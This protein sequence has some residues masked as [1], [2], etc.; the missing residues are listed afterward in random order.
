[1][2]QVYCLLCV[3]SQYQEYVQG[4]GLRK[5]SFVSVSCVILRRNNLYVTIINF[6]DQRF[7]IHAINR[8]WHFT[9]HRQLLENVIVDVRSHEL[10]PSGR[11]EQLE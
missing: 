9:Q 3:V 5:A 1:M 8:H 4:R 2:I 7:R 11:Y 6:A 10:Q